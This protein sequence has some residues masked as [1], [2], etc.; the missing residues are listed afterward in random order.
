MFA[1]QVKRRGEVER[2]V[3]YERYMENGPIWDIIANDIVRHE[4]FRDIPANVKELYANVG[5]RRAGRRRLRNF[6][7]RE[8]RK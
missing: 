5:S 4:K 2:G 7:A 1:R 6:I 8:P 3:I